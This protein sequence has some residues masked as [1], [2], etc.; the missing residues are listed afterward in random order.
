MTSSDLTPLVPASRFGRRWLA[1]A[2]AAGIV[3]FPIVAKARADTGGSE[4]LL[5]TWAAAIALLVFGSFAGLQLALG[6]APGK[7]TTALDEREQELR[8]RA[9]RVSYLLLTSVSVAGTSVAVGFSQGGSVSTGPSAVAIVMSFAALLQAR[10]RLLC[11]TIARGG[12]RQV[13]RSVELTA[14]DRGRAFHPLRATRELRGARAADAIGVSS[15][16]G[17]R[18]P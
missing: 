14:F 11:A 5:E 10:V 16:A 8:N 9:Y 13:S 17:A 3:A 18:R 7:H 1:V 2:C 12:G 15:S 6:D 4:A